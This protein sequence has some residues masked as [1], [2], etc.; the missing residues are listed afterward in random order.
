[1]D[2]GSCTGFSSVC[3]GIALDASVA[4][5]SFRVCA[6]VFT[7]QQH[8][9]CAPAGTAHSFV[10]GDSADDLDASGGNHRSR[11]ARFVLAGSDFGVSFDCFGALDQWV[12]PCSTAHGSATA[13]DGVVCFG[14]DAPMALAFVETLALAGLS[15]DADGHVG[16]SQSP[17]Q[18]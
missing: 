7:G 3:G 11:D 13:L 6:L 16:S 12:A 9:R 2:A 14:G 15:S 1:M 5:A 4:A 18:R 10:D 17:A 8:D